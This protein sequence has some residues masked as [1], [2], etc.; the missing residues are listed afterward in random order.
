VGHG[1][2][3]ASLI[4]A[5][6]DCDTELVKQYMPRELGFAPR[7]VHPFSRAGSNLVALLVH[8]N[9]GPKA[10][11]STLALA[12]AFV[13]RKGSSRANALVIRYLAALLRRDV[14]VAAECLPQIAELYR[15]M[16]WLVQFND[17]LKFFGIFVHGL[18]NLAHRALP[19]DQFALLPPVDHPVFW[20]GFDRLTKER[21]F[22][23]GKLVDGLSLTAELSGLQRLFASPMSF[24]VKNKHGPA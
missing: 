21:Q 20:K 4:H 8:D 10:I 3:F 15:K 12:D 24:E 19:T 6:A 22:T 14:A 9:I 11:E 23:P 18:Y 2:N 16:E 5:M 17:F 1:F 7:G 13:N